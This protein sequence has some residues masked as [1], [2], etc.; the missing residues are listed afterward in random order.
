[1]T[2][3]E[4]SHAPAFGANPV[5]VVINNGGWQIFR[6]V[7]DRTDLL[8]IPPWPYAKLAEDWGGLGVRVER[9]SE[10]RPALDLAHRN[11]RQFALIEVTVAPDD[12]SPVT[13]KYIKAAATHARTRT[14]PSARSRR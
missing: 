9:L 10:L 14:D 3:F 8:S 7:T 1:M 11:R 13:L 4:V 2:G 5:V 12:L 6:P